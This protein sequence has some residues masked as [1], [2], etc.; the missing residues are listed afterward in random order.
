M[1]LFKRLTILYRSNLGKNKLH[2]IHQ[3]YICIIHFF[4]LKHG[5]SGQNLL[6]IFKIILQ[7]IKYINVI[8]KVNFTNDIYV[9]R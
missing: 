3:S 6:K 1:N 2:N 7:L 5:F 8:Q 9:T 4:L